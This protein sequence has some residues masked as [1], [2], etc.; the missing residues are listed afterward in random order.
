MN[1]G[2]EKMEE[3]LP[4]GCSYRRHRAYECCFERC[5]AP[6][7]THRVRIVC[8]LVNWKSV[9]IPI[10]DDCFR[11]LLLKTPTYRMQQLKLFTS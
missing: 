2:G 4:P 11:E 8:R 3:Q 1:S 6:S 9:P 7:P 10:C 5:H